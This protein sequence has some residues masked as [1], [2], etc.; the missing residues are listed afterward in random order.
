CGASMSNLSRRKLLT[1]GLVTTAAGSAAV[2]AAAKVA[3]RYG[4]LPP[5][6]GGVFG[7]GETLNYATHRVFGRHAL[8]REFT[9]AQ[10]SRPPFANEVRPLGDEFK[11]LEEKGF[12]DWRLDVKGM[13][14]TPKTFSLE[15]LRRLPARSQITHLACEEGWSYIG[16]WTGVPLAHILDLV[17]IH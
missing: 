14:R 15:E 1:T 5:D 17:G 8:A 7:L 3:R 10:I 13:V 4:L 9:P 12:P 6:A 2:V 11:R 16:Q